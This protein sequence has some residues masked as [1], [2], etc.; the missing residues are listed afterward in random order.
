VY[1]IRELCNLLEVRH[2]NKVYDDE[3]FTPLARAL[4]MLGD[5]KGKGKAKPDNGKSQDPLLNI[6][7][8]SNFTF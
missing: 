2:L 7:F 6:Q 3:K 5:E 8:P 4:E 1:P